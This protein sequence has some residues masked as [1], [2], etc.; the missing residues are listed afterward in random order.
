ML[1]RCIQNPLFCSNH[2]CS[3]HEIQTREKNLRVL[4]GARGL[5]DPGGAALPHGVQ[6]HGPAAGGARSARGRPGRHAV[7][8]PGGP[9]PLERAQLR[10]AGRV[11]GRVGTL[12]LGP[13]P[14][15]LT[16]PPVAITR[17]GDD[18]R[19]RV[20][21]LLQTGLGRRSARHAV[22]RG[23]RAGPGC[24]SLRRRRPLRR[25]GRV[26]RPLGPA[27]KSPLRRGVPSGGEPGALR[28]DQRL[29]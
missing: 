18:F 20:E 15:H 1:V 13:R 26:Q 4:P 28:P 11:T 21:P 3:G 5:P 9:D 10:R 14:G 24:R 27:G 2:V 12:W 23:L 19:P 6:H 29:L 22:G 25:H 7:R 17:A 16:R 8:A